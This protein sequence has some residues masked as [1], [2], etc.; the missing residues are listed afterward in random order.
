MWWLAL[1]PHSR[2]F[3]NQL[4]AGSFCVEFAC[5]PRVRVG[6]L[7]V[8]LLSP[9]VQKHA[10][11]L[12]GVSKIVLSPVE[13][14]PSLVPLGVCLSF[15]SLGFCTFLGSLR[16]ISPQS[17]WGLSLLRSSAVSNVLL[18]SHQGQYLYLHLCVR[19]V[20]RARK[21]RNEQENLL[22]SVLR[23]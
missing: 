19:D 7:R 2:G 4:P 18:F 21:L 11:R 17:C 5:S 8:L 10:V 15:G 3:Q 6:S 16:F 1:L 22:Q 23:M 9:T 12:T 14:C 20:L 13:V